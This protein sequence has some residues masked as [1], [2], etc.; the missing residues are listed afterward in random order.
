M[1]AM[2]F[3]GVDQDRELGKL[4]SELAGLSAENATALINL[5]KAEN[6]YKGCANDHWCTG[7]HCN[8]PTC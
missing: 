2:I 8:N 4:S 1:A 6:R 7:G 3:E 5:L